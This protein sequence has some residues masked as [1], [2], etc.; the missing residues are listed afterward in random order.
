[1]G[2][3]GTSGPVLFSH[4]VDHREEEECGEEVPINI[5]LDME[6]FQKTEKK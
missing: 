1:M 6:A 5:R 4:L 3:S 2:Y